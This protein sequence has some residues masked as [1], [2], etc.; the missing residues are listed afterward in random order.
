MVLTEGQIA[1]VKVG[2]VISAGGICNAVVP[3]Q[4]NVV[5]AAVDIDYIPSVSLPS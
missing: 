1:L 2:I 3:G 5:I 4:I